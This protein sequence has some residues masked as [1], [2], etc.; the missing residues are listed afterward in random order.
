MKTHILYNEFHLGDCL[1]AL[2]LLRAVAKQAPDDQFVFFTH[3]CNLGQLA[4]A[5]SDIPNL[6]LFSFENPMWGQERHR[7]IN[8]WKNAEG[9]WESS[10]YRWDWSAY[11]LW[12]HAAIARRMG[13][14]SPLTRREHL[15]FDYPALDK[16]VYVGFP[17]DFLVIACEP[18]S[19]QFAP[20]AA[21]GSRYMDGLIQELNKKHSVLVVGPTSIPTSDTLRHFPEGR[22]I[23]AVGHESI[24]ARNIIGVATGPLWPC[25][26]TH[27]NHAHEGRKFIGLLSNGE[28]LNMPHWQQCASVKEV[29]DIA[30]KEGW[31]V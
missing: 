16:Y 6:M 4:E 28:Q 30:R 21:H 8:C 11:T 17:F 18:C 15:L 24:Y 27:N 12:H 23:S 14:E 9:A 2:H 7:A 5:V 13:F 3:E 29:M 1:I 20:M 19:G 31:I 22:A 26:N 25:I 10:P